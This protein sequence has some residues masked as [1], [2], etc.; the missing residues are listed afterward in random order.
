MYSIS[1]YVCMY[2]CIYGQ[3]AYIYDNWKS[4]SNRMH[5]CENLYASRI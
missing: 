1:M 4:G 3:Y 2:V 5:A